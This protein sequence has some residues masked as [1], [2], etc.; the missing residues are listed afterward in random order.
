MPTTTVLSTVGAKEMMPTKREKREERRFRFGYRCDP[1][2]TRDQ[3]Y[4]SGHAHDD[5]WTSSLHLPP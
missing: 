3:P 2:V 5:L 4:V 1:K